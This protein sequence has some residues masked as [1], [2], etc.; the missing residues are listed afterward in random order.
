MEVMCP[1]H[2]LASK[3]YYGYSFVT[4]YAGWGLV[5]I[6]FYPKVIKTWAQGI[7]WDWLAE[8]GQEIAD[9]IEPCLMRDHWGTKE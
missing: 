1:K 7:N 9:N 3:I 8:S 6:P 4:G 2:D 5:V